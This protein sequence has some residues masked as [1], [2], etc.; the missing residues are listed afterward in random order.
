VLLNLGVL[1]AYYLVYS[2]RAAD[3]VARYDRLTSTRQQLGA[4]RDRLERVLARL[5]NAQAGLD[6]FYGERLGTEGERLTGVIAE[7][8]DLART[9]G[10]EPSAINYTLEAL[11]DHGMVRRALNFTVAGRYLDLRRLINLL[12]LSSFFITLD[13]V[14][15]TEGGQGVELRISLELSALFA[16]SGAVP[17]VP[18]ASGRRAG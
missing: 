9:A 14:G 3:R 10:L 6:E 13:R 11:E 8:R 18:V 12:E 15:L 7:I 4:E 17:P 1:A 5:E 2:G 16:Q